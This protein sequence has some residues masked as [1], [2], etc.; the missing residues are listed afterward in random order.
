MTKK[1]QNRFWFLFV[2]GI[3][4]FGIMM[5]IWTVKQATSVPVHESNN[6]MLKYQ[7]ADMNI[8]E[9][10]ELEAKFNAKYSIKL[11]DIEFLK[12][13]DDAQ[14]TNAK[15]AQST[16]I[17]LNAGSNS[18][19]YSITHNQKSVENAKVTFLLT[20]PHSR[21]DDHLEESVSYSNNHY[22]TKAV[23]LTKKGRYTLQLKVEIDG[24]IGYSEVSAYLID[25]HHR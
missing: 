6:Y 14:N 7:M 23:E 9:I 4:A 1:N 21:Y 20:R 11:E 17:K 10:M 18:F 2:M 12:L 16:P 8:N 22:K 5:I 19:T 3:L 13:E 15:R 25:S 24:L